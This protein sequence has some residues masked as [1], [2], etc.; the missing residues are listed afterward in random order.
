MGI[1]GDNAARLSQDEFQAVLEEIKGLGLTDLADRVSQVYANGVVV[2]TIIQELEGR[3]AHVEGL[4]AEMIL[5]LIAAGGR[6]ARPESFR[7]VPTD[8]PTDVKVPGQ[9]L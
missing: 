9:Y 2:N 8:E 7:N 3:L 6:G 4:L 5:S 1:M